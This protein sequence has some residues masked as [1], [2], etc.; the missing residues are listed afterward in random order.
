M[1]NTELLDF[2]FLKSGFSVLLSE[3][4]KRRFINQFKLAA[5][6]VLQAKKPFMVYLYGKTSLKK[7]NLQL[8]LWE[9][10]WQ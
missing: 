10:D 4:I 1:G 6:H 2:M 7:S 8:I 5:L 3:S 9:N